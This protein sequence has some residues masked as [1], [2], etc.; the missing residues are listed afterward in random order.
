MIPNEDDY[1]LVNP[2]LRKVM[3]GIYEGRT[4][5]PVRYLCDTRLEQIDNQSF[6]QLFF[7]SKG[8]T[9]DLN[10]GCTMCNY[11]YGKSRFPN[12]KAVLEEIK[13]KT[14]LLPKH[15]HE[16]VVG[17]VG[18]LLDEDEVPSELLLQILE[19]LSKIDCDE[20]TVETR[21]DSVNIQKLQLLKRFIHSKRITLELGIESA[22][23]WCLRNCINKNTSF[24]R[25]QETIG[26]AHKEGVQICG[27]VGIG[28]PFVSEAYSIQS[29]VTTIRRL[30][31]LKVSCIALFAYNIRPGTLLEW[32]WKRGM[33]NC[34]SLWGLVE[35]LSRF[36]D[37]ELQH[38][39]I[40]WYR[41]YYVDKA[42]ILRMP[43]LC[44]DCEDTV[45][46]L[47]DAYRNNPCSTTLQP[48]IQFDCHCKKKWKELYLSE[49]NYVDFSAVK[50]IYIEMAKEFS[51]P[52]ELLEHELVY[53]Q[54]TLL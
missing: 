4:S 54:N 47:L 34:T 38:I 41:N 44:S 1:T 9:H 52:L 43:S 21:A 3:K 15:L 27:N 39:Q 7:M 53:M 45:L 46:S 48:L 19:I 29:A 33:Y 28:F 12:P 14:E 2:V 25:I 8:C 37:E 20:F 49:P 22:D 26:M 18:S 24:D 42:K 11:G 6:A 17:P 51:I 30:L 40:S 50:N 31:D 13:E 10:G 35:V 23:L 32:L 5:Y 16:I 36:S